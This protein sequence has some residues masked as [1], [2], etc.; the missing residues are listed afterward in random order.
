M[1]YLRRASSIVVLALALFMFMLVSLDAN[2]DGLVIIQIRAFTGEG[3]VVIQTPTQ[4]FTQTTSDSIQKVAFPESEAVTITAIPAD[5]NSFHSIITVDRSSQRFYTTTNQIT[6]PVTDTTLLYAQFIRVQEV[7]T[8][9]IDWWIYDAGGVITLTD[10]LGSQRFESGQNL[11]VQTLLLTDTVVLSYEPLPG[12]SANVEVDDQP[13]TSPVTL[14]V[15][16]IRKI[17][18]NFEEAEQVNGPL[19]LPIIANNE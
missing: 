17:E 13:V 9:T 5:G 15:A 10:S 11:G 2:T 7:T 8:K 3:T 4:I 19:Y 6:I 16:T 12:M 14:T 1:F 18:A